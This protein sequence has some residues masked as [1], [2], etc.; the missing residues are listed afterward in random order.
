M[1]DNEEFSE[2]AI[3]KKE[4]E[5]LKTKI[6]SIKEVANNLEIYEEMASFKVS[7]INLNQSKTYVSTRERLYRKINEL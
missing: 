2:I 3:L 4:L 7:G 6:T 1:E 5:D